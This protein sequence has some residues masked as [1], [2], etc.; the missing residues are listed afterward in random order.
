MKFGLQSRITSNFMDLSVIILSFNTKELLLNCLKS[1]FKQTKGIK[2]EVIVV[3][4]GSVDGS[5]ALVKKLAKSHK[6]LVLL[7]NSEN[8]GF[9]SGNNLGIEKAKGDYIMLLNSDTILKDNSLKKLVNFSQRHPKI[10][11]VGPRLL[12]KDGT[13]QPSTSPFLTLP[14]LFLWLVTGDRFLYRSP[15]KTLSVD[16]VMG[17]VFL[18]KKEV[19]DQ[20]GLLD[21]NFFMY[22][23]EMEWCYRAKQAGWQVWFYP[24]AEVFHLIRGSSPSGKQR[25]IWWIYEGLY[26]FYTK[27]FAPWQSAVVK[28]LL[29]TKA[30]VV[31]IIGCIIADRQLKQT[32]AKAFKLAGKP[33]S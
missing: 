22:V 7:K 18:V 5:P 10:G 20:V 24:G 23:E 6:N 11:I 3:D 2:Y 13:H 30:L 32:Y 28:L 27:H 29:R 33:S 17:A 31:L 25:A 19:I 1:I 21:E 16:W 14:K 12:N 15:S 8:L 9:A 4:N 26:F